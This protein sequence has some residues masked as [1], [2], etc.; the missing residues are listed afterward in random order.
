MDSCISCNSINKLFEWIGNRIFKGINIWLLVL[1][2]VFSWSYFLHI[3][4]RK[5]LNFQNKKMMI[6]I[7]QHTF[8]IM[9]LHCM[10]F[11]IF[12]GI[13]YKIMGEPTEVEPTL[14][15]ISFSSIGMR[16][17]YILVGM[18]VPLLICR[19]IDW[20][21]SYKKGLYQNEIKRT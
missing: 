17:G 20:V 18:I 16:C 21:K 19:G 4:C 5:L 12:D 6:Y 8:E 2:Y 13:I 11:K 7:G 9:A 14:Y 1:C 10:V 15:P 3:S